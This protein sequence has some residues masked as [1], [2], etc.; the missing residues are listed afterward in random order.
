MPAKSMAQF[1]LMQAAKHDPG[2]RKR[3]GITKSVAE[4]FTSSRPKKLPEHVAKARA[5]RK[6]YSRK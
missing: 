6:H 2:V 1:R 4:E 5:I 3:T